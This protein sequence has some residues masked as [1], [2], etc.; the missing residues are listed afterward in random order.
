[1][2]Y[3]RNNNDDDHVNNLLDLGDMTYIMK[4]FDWGPEDGYILSWKIL[5]LGWGDGK[6]MSWKIWLLYGV[7]EIIH[8]ES[9]K[10]LEEL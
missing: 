7:M 6:F 3:N 4:K 1:M 5:N 2:K 9:T 10:I 8:H